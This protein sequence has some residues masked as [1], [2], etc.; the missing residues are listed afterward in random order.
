MLSL[1][2]EDTSEVAKSLDLLIDELKNPI[3]ASKAL[4]LN[5]VKI[6]ALFLT[7]LKFYM[8]REIMQS[9]LELLRI[10]S[11]HPDAIFS[12]AFNQNLFEA[13]VNLMFDLELYLPSAKVLQVLSSNIYGKHF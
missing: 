2:S 6:L 7:D 13:L 10:F 3:K 11:L 1:E 12:I 9:V 5:I 4:K 8:H